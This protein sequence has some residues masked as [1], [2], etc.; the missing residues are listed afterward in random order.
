VISPAGKNISHA[1][2][3]PELRYANAGCDTT[4]DALLCRWRISVQAIHQIFQRAREY[5][6]R[7]LRQLKFVSIPAIPIKTEAS[8]T[9][10]DRNGILASICLPE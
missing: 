6:L 4:A 8:I 9:F 7:L 3:Q 2:S 10:S 5:G 1:M